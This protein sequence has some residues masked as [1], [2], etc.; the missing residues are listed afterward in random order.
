MIVDVGERGTEAVKILTAY[1]K[2]CLQL[3]GVPILRTRYGGLPF[4]KDGELGIVALCYAPLRGRLETLD[5]YAS[6]R[7]E[8]WRHLWNMVDSEVGAWRDILGMF[9]SLVKSGEVDKILREVGIELYT[10]RT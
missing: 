1:V 2:K 3:G 8:D 7:S 9:G 10:A 6:N 5:I 4:M